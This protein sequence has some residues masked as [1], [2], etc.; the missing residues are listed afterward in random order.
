MNTVHRL[1]ATVTLTASLFASM[2]VLSSCGDYG[3]KTVEKLTNDKSRNCETEYMHLSVR[4]FGS[5]TEA[6]Y[7]IGDFLDEFSSA[8]GCKSCCDHA[9]KIK[10]EFS[11]MY[12]F[13]E[14][15]SSYD[16]FLKDGQV[17]DGKFSSSTYETVRKTWKSLYEKEK[18][19]RYNLMLNEITAET[20]KP[21]LEKCAK[22]HAVEHFNWD[23]VKYNVTSC[24][25][26]GTM[27]VSNTS[28]NKGKTATGT[29][30]VN[31]EGS[32]LGL[33]T[34]SADVTV[35]GTINVASDGTRSFVEGLS[36]RVF[37]EG[38]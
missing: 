15:N 17:K 16:R 14:N 22:Q 27:N 21:Y 1:V 29:F 26:R 10:A 31:L 20:F 34:K 32:G 30:H 9:S 2:L 33:S 5:C 28:D 25:F 19:R 35:C 37:N 6:M 8:Q 24:E 18:T 12:S 4:E 7:A 13:L 38:N 3:P 36:Y 23:F 11:E